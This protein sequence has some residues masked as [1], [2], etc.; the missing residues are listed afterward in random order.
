MSNGL[1]IAAV[2]TTLTRLLQELPQDELEPGEG[3]E[4]TA[5]PLDKAS[6]NVQGNRINLFL[7][8]TTL[9]GAWRNTD[10]PRQTRPSEVGQPP[11]AVDLHYLISAFTDSAD[12]HRS[13]RLLGR[14]MRILHDHPVLDRKDIR[15]ALEAADLHAQIERIRIRPAQMSND[16]SSKLW[17]AFHT[18]YRLS[19]AYEVS[20]VLIEGGRASRSPLPVLK[21][22]SK[23]QGVVTVASPPPTLVEARPPRPFPS[24]RLGDA[25]TLVG[26]HLGG[27]NLIARF[28]NPHLPAPIEVEP[29]LDATA[30]GLTVAI[31]DA[32]QDP[33][34]LVRWVAGFYTAAVVVKQPG[35][36]VWTTNE[37]PLA[38]APIIA[39]SPPTA[40]PGNLQLTVTCRPR[41]RDTQRAVLLFADR[42]A[43]PTTL[44]TPADSAEPTTLTFAL[45]QV[46]A[47]T[48]TVRLRVDGVDSIPLPI[49]RPGTPTPSEFDRQQQ[50]EVNAP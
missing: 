26:S 13:H 12:D 50:V 14:A 20:V 23:D 7:Y 48:Y 45:G 6:Q 15:T 34:A 35:V 46:S 32:G 11:L 3:I 9:N 27:G 33:D 43:S 47:G 22:G 37:V 49:A 40:A 42:Q 30:D 41:V 44:S 16:E 19:T 25:V 18:P 28:A 38:L 21:R 1:A 4:V 31:R 17:S 29:S 8:Q 36:P 5:R 10:I 24:A 39:V 2:T